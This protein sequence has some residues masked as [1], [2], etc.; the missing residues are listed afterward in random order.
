MSNFLLITGIVVVVMGLLVFFTWRLQ[1]RGSTLFLRPLPPYTLLKGKVGHAVESGSQLHITL[2]RASLTSVATPTSLAAL[3]ILDTLAKDG[4]A[5]GTP[6]LAT[7]GDATLLPAAQSS[8]LY[9]YS[10]AQ[11]TSGFQPGAAQFLANDT[12]AFPYAA[13]VT[14]VIHQDKVSST[15]AVGRFGAELALITAAG[16]RQQ[17]EQV[18]G[19]DD[20]LALA[21]ATAVSPHVL[22]GEELLAAGAYLE[23]QPSQLAS[24]Q[25]QDVLRL[26]VILVLV[27]TAVYRLL[28]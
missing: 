4:C 18:I 3:T 6:P 1:R 17:G 24:V 7:V 26:V 27:V 11:F 14:N 12:D 20:P 25:V 22:I 9:A 13:G 16:E 8:L 21:L 2:G 10:R 5:N 19:A 15:V 28:V 23:G